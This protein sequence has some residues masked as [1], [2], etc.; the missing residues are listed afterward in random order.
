MTDEMHHNT[1]EIWVH[2][3]TEK[4][5]QR[6]RARVLKIAENDPNQLIPVYIDSYGGYVDALAT[7]IET[8][9]EVDNRFITI[10]SGKAMSCGAILFSHGDIR[11]VGDYSR[12]MIHNVSK[13][14]WGDCYSL[15]AASDEA[16]RL[17]NVF[18]GLLAENC[19]ITLDELQKR[20]R[21]ATDS[22]EI[23]LSPN[24]AKE[25]GI[26]D[27][28]GTPNVQPVLYW[29]V[30]TKL[31]KG[32]LEDDVRSKK[33]KVKKKKTTKKKTTKRKVTRKTKKS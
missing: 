32:R 15:K 5:A 24:D 16:M 20:I 31:P 10:C 27:F 33:K 21:D 14:S 1:R 30:E 19:D 28:V 26:A 6:F 29:Q 25:F 12:I 17:N 4:A 7:M 23:W 13:M 3:F 22:K 2:D 8:M 11:Y 9:N 18:M